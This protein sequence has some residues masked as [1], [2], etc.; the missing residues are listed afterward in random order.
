MPESIGSRLRMTRSDN[1]LRMQRRSAVEAMTG[2]SPLIR[3]AAG[4]TAAS[5]SRAKRMIIKPMTAF[6]KPITVQGSV[7]VKNK[8]K[9]RSR[10][11]NPPGESAT[12]VVQSSAAIVATTST[13]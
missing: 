11:P 7:T 13:A 1:S 12:T 5:G 3:A 6:Q 8:R 10:K 2:S 9:S 4:L